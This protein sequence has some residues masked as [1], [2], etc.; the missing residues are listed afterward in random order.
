[1]EEFSARTRETN[2]IEMASRPVDV[3]VIGGGIVGAWTALTAARRG[4]RT[5]LVEKGDFASGTSGKT[6]RLIH[7]GLRYLQRLRI[8]VVRR[9]A[10]E[11]DIL[12]KIAPSL[13]RPL[14][15]L[16]PVY[17]DR[18]PPRWQL[19]M[20]LWLYDALS[21]DKVLPRRKWLTR[22]E[23]LTREPALSGD[24]LVAAAVYADAITSDARLVIALVRKAAEAGALVANYARVT[25]I[26]RESGRVA[27]AMVFDEEA[28][29]VRSV[30]ARAVVNATGVWVNELQNKGTRLRLRPTKG[31][32]IL[33]PRPRIGNR[34]AVTLPA[35][36]GRVT[37]VI[38]WGELALV[39][40]TD[41]EHGGSKDEVEAGPKDVEYLL[42]A[43][44]EGFPR[45]GLTV[46][47]IVGTYA[48]LRPL[49]D[50]GETKESDISREHRIL[51][52]PDGLIS[53][54]GGKL[55]TGRAMALEILSRIERAWGRKGADI[56]RDTLGILLES[57]G[58]ALD[59]TNLSALAA[60]A[61][62]EEMAM[63]VDDFLLRRTGLFYERPDQAA[64]MVPDIVEGMAGAL[65]W[66]ADRKA[67]EKERYRRLVERNRRW[68]GGARDG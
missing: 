60:R 65:G 43:V 23:T 14:N 16:I 53:V 68:R 7:G 47:D 20:G 67:E 13:V 24:R 9:A 50:T 57:T 38:P 28:R 21:K 59:E 58:F 42:R 56:P 36:D 5:A 33:V 1:M 27:G 19:R 66:G 30:R 41:T 49:I 45:A 26:V 10:R 63:H 37:F 29:A 32:H 62:R 12:L 52:D 34:E 22:D 51:V 8:G 6:S 35:H 3:L 31:I 40:T 48:G 64:R 25:E 2:L 55:T 17:R 54:A 11:R 18:G 61:A 15:F 44:N 4:H 39:G 46:A